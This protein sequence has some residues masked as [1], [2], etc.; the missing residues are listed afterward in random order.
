MKT[1]GSI[2]QDPPIEITRLA[3]KRGMISGQEVD[4]TTSVWWDAYPIY[5]VEIAIANVQEKTLELQ[6][7]NL[8]LY[9]VG[10]NTKFARWDVITDRFPIILKHNRYCTF[11]CETWGGSYSI[12]YIYVK[13]DG[14]WLGYSFYDLEYRWPTHWSNISYYIDL[15]A[16]RRTQILT[17]ILIYLVVVGFPF[18]VWIRRRRKNH[19]RDLQT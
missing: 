13:V 5:Y 3:E 4:G 18:A 12:Q 9:E 17:L 6:Q 1:K 7:I 2:H 8:S 14:E 16:L 19:N 15:E 11:I 10:W